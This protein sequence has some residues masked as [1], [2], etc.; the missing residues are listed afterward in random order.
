MPSDASPSKQDVLDEILRQDGTLPTDKPEPPAS[1]E[2][3]NKETA[4]EL[5][6][7]KLLAFQQHHSSKGHWSIFMMALL[8]GLVI[9]Q[10][11]L[12]V[13]VGQ[14]KWDF[15]RYE[16]LLPLLLVQNLAQIIGLAHV[17]V[18]SLFDSFKE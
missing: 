1:I 18:K 13:K 11:I 9:F 16:W 14:G 10:I 15:T 3:A 5:A 8:A 12:L 4:R 6:Y 7:A 2:D 17:V